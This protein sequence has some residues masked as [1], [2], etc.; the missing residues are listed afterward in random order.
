M[1]GLGSNGNI[2]ILNTLIKETNYDVAGTMLGFINFFPF[3]S[4]GILQ[5]L[6]PIFI[7]WADKN[8]P[9]GG[10]THSPRAYQLGLWLTNTAYLTVSTI[11]TFFIKETYKL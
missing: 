5:I 3:F 10:D 2:T 11:S 7:N 4:T 8:K 9:D 6:S 1:F